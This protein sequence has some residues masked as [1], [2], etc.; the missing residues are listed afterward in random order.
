[1][2]PPAARRGAAGWGAARPAGAAVGAGVWLRQQEAD[3]QATRAQRE[4]QARV[5]VETA[6]GRAD[7][8]RRE[9]RWKDA[10]VVL[11]VN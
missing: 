2:D 10:L 5:A 4:G 8:P 7:D 1:M 3:R 6:L 9:E 11:A